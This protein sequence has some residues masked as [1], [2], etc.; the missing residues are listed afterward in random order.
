MAVH[1]G[2]VTEGNRDQLGGILVYPPR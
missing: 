1:T 2:A